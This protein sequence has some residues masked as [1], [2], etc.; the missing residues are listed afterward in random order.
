MLSVVIICRN[1]A[2]F[3]EQ[4]VQ[5]AL[6]QTPPF[7]RVV[8]V[9]DHSDDGST[10]ILT[11]LAETD[12]RITLL[13]HSTPRG[14]GPARNTGIAELDGGFFCMLDGDD[15][16]LD[17]ATEKMHASMSQDPDA[18]L[19]CFEGLRVSEGE[20]PAVSARQ[21]AGVFTTL[22][23]KKLPMIATSFSVN[24]VYRL[25]LIKSNAIEFP[26]GR[27][28]DVPWFYETI[29][30]ANRV[31]STSVPI[32]NFRVHADS[33]L[34]RRSEEH[35][36]AFLQWDRTENLVNAYEG[37]E[38][39]MLFDFMQVNGFL[40]FARIFLAGRIPEELEPDFVEKLRRRYAPLR[41]IKALIPDHPNHVRG[42]RQ[43]RKIRRYLKAQKEQSTQ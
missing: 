34:K 26:S 37:A 40:H 27:Y 6:H 28:E 20:E 11:R 19:H 39:K 33:F 18:D 15:Y 21:I 32:V 2:R 42:R 17:D 8:V 41:K 36:E 7:E 35:F 5:S 12:A 24:K 4:A 43:F 31:R 16:F 29:L 3:I 1:N 22:E 23:E 14:P 13:K 25:E 10:D 9:D 38:R 30:K